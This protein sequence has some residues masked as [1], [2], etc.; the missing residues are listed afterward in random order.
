M[1]KLGWG[2]TKARIRMRQRRDNRIVLRLKQVA[3]GAALAAVAALSL[4]W[5]AR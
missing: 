3:V 4:G 1:T 2:I 5:V